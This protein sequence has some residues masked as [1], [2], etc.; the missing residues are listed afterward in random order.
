[1]M[2]W[3]CFHLHIHMHLCDKLLTGCDK[4]RSVIH[5]ALILS[6]SCVINHFNNFALKMIIEMI[7]TQ[8]ALVLVGSFCLCKLLKM[9]LYA[10]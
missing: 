2:F 5:A 8:T 9:N 10:L 6:P 4:F 3:D 1:M 7:T